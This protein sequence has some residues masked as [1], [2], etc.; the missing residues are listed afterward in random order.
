MTLTEQFKKILDKYA[1]IGI[2]GSDPELIKELLQVVKDRD[3]YIV[4][5]DEEIDWSALGSSSRY[6][7]RLQNIFNAEI[8][9]KQKDT[10]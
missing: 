10:L 8:R 4:G 5:K 6:E 9:Q 7:R 3:T 1:R 2:E